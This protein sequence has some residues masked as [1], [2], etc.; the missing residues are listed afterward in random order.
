M[1]NSDSNADYKSQKEAFDQAYKLSEQQ[2]KANF[3]EQRATLAKDK[4]EAQNDLTQQQQK[5]NETAA[6]MKQK[7]L[8]VT[9]AEHQATMALMQHKLDSTAEVAK[10]TTGMFTDMEDM[11]DANGFLSPSSLAKLRAKYPDAAMHANN[12]Q[13][14][15]HEMERFDAN[16]RLQNSLPKP[17]FKTVNVRD[18][19]GKIIESAHVPVKPG[20]ADDITRDSLVSQ[21]D[22]LVSQIGA[23]KGGWSADNAAKIQQ[24][25]AIKGKLGYVPVDVTGV[26]DA[27]PS[28][29]TTQATPILVPAPPASPDSAPTPVPASPST[30]PAGSGVVPPTTPPTDVAATSPAPDS[31]QPDITPDAHAQLKPGDKF[32]WKGQQLTKQ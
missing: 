28:A 10:Q 1:E 20:E 3:A 12:A 6:G 30:A 21:H 8:E 2:R 17:G 16:R 15:N 29:P 18:E 4:F 23:A 5:L 22:A 26:T 9:I 31:P 27:T 19:S 11:R 32:W 24:L 7:E 13:A 14:L 25:N